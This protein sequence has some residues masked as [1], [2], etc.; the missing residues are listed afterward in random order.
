MAQEDPEEE[1]QEKQRFLTSLGQ[2]LERL[3]RRIDL[4][5]GIAQSIATSRTRLEQDAEAQRLQARRR[6]QDQANEQRQIRDQLQNALSDKRRPML[7]AKAHYDLVAG[8]CRFFEEMVEA[9]ELELQGQIS[10]F[11]YNQHFIG[12]RA[13]ELHARIGALRQLIREKRPGLLPPRAKGEEK[14]ELER[15]IAQLQK[16]IDRLKAMRPK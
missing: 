7:E 14:E 1:K 16:E 4:L 10:Q 3:Q 9:Q 11:R 8:R 5:H 13:A 2:D 12:A 6:E 15:S